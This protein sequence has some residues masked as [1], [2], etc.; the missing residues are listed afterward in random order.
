[1]YCGE[2]KYTIY[3][4]GQKIKVGPKKVR[5]RSD[6]WIESSIRGAT[7]HKLNGSINFFV[8]IN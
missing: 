5:S 8:P 4:D 3:Q 2:G 7:S 6:L 1:M